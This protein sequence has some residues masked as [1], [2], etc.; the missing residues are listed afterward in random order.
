MNRSDEPKIGLVTH[1]ANF[2]NKKYA[3]KW[4]VDM[5]RGKHNKTSQEIFSINEQMEVAAYYKWQSRGCPANDSLT[6]WVE[7]CE[8]LAPESR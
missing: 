4:S 7:A 3:K 5:P 8:E 6:D 1:L 2:L